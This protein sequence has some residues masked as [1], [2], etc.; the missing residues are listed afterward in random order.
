MWKK[1]NIQPEILEIA[2][3]LAQLQAMQ[4]YSVPATYFDELPGTIMHLL[5]SE[6]KAAF[7]FEAITKDPYSAPAGYF[8]GLADNILAKVKQQAIATNEVDEELMAIAPALVGL[9]KKQVYSAPAAYFDKLDVQVDK[10]PKVQ[11]K[12]VKMY[13]VKR[14]MQYLA[15][16]VVIAI[17][18][19]SAYIFLDKPEATGTASNATNTIGNISAALDALTDEE[20]V[21]YLQ[22]HST[23]LNTNYSSYLLPIDEMDLNEVIKELSDEDLQQFLQQYSE[24]RAAAKG[25]I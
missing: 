18:A 19:I 25:G 20:I 16:A 2:P 22:A 14:V 24:P 10:T 4:V 12:V 3:A 21:E 1:D 7:N 23:T 8:D 11:A 9:N 6:E 5:Q 13:S 17:M 15:A